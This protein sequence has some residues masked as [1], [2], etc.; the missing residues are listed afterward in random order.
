MELKSSN[1]FDY[2]YLRSCFLQWPEETACKYRMSVMFYKK[3]FWLTHRKKF[4]IFSKNMTYK[5]FRTT[6]N[7][8][9]HINGNYTASFI[10]LYIAHSV[11]ST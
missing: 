5:N 8:F 10:Y 3:S 4:F 2:L 11:D 6:L 7:S 1:A 9:D